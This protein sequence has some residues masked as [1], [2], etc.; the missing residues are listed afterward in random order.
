MTHLLPPIHLL[1]VT[2]IF[3]PYCFNTL[4]VDTPP[5]CESMLHAKQAADLSCPSNLIVVGCETDAK[6]VMPHSVEDFVSDGVE[7]RGVIT[8]DNLFRPIPIR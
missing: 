3:L 7:G 2:A 4:D 6:N 5:T 1:L 8:H